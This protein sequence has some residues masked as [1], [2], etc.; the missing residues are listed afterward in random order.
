MD[1]GRHALAAGFGLGQLLF[2]LAQLLHLCLTEGR[3]LLQGGLD[4]ARLLLQLLE[5][6]LVLPQLAR[7]AL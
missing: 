6:L 5:L 3:Q 1:R 7:F 4:G 2:G